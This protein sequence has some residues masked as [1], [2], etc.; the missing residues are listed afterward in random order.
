ML[1]VD[2]IPIWIW[3]WM[4]LDHQQNACCWFHSHPQ[5]FHFSWWRGQWNGGL[6]DLCNFCFAHISAH[7]QKLILREERGMSTNQTLKKHWGFH[8]TEAGRFRVE[9]TIYLHIGN[10]QIWIFGQSSVRKPIS[11][12]WKKLWKILIIGGEMVVIYFARSK[13]LPSEWHPFFIYAINPDDFH[14]N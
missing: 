7:A 13:R 1:V 8:F 6:L 11:Y 4:H 12:I 10:F 2:F 14:W 3:I 9:V 5:S